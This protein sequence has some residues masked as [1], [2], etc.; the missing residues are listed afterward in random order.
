MNMQN[1]KLAKSSS[2]EIENDKQTFLENFKIGNTVKFID[3]LGHDEKA[4]NM[5]LIEFKILNSYLGKT[6]KIIDSIIMEDVPEP[7]NMFLTVQFRDGYKL[8]DANYFAFG[9]AEYKV[10]NFTKEKEKIQ[11]ARGHDE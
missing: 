1:L 7:Y 11:L 10:I 6:C 4:W 9:P 2:T 8:Y 5:D 3:L